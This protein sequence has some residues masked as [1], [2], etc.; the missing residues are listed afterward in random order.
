[1][2]MEEATIVKWHKGV[3]ESFEEGDAIYEVETDKVTQVVEAT[4]GGTLVEILIP[5][6]EDAQVGDAICVVEAG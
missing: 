6:G 1:M 5:E 3:G 2:N 4:G